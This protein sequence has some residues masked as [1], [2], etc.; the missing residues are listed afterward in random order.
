MAFLFNGL[1]LITGLVITMFGLVT[2]ASSAS[3]LLIVALGVGMVSIAWFLDR[4]RVRRRDA[5]LQ[6]AIADRTAALT[7]RPWHAHERLEI[8]QNW[9]QF[10]A[11]LGVLVFGGLAV[12]LGFSGPETKWPLV[13][14]GLV[15]LATG[16]VM[17]PPVLAGIGIPALVL[18]RNGLTT[19]VDGA[20]PWSAIHGIYLQ[21]VTY[22]GVT[23]YSLVFRVP[24]YAQ[25]VQSIH[26]SRL[27]LSLFGLGPLRSGQFAVPLRPGKERPETI[28]AVARYLW[29]SATGREYFW[30]PFQS[31]AEIE[32]FRNLAALKSAMP[33][34]QDLDR[35]FREG[36]EQAIAQMESGMAR[37]DQVN[38]HLAVIEKAQ[39]KRFRMLSWALFFSL[40]CVLAVFIW[41]WVK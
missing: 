5:A 16:A 39:R 21:V 15:I 10:G 22:R 26:W 4:G 34:P 33:S 20:V 2:S 9:W 37:L 31:E 27:W 38:H 3:N 6:K 29:R 40:A 41:P 1:L 36:P 13:L 8:P 11:T 23:R 17:L 14:G 7:S 25:V 32:S 30:S 24:S 18:D 35:A 12:Q 19:P 28:E